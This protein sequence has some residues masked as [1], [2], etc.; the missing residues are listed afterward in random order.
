MDEGEGLDHI[1]S[2][3]I[4]RVT[5]QLVQ[6]PASH[7]HVAHHRQPLTLGQMRHVFEQNCGL[8]FIAHKQHRLSHGVGACTVGVGKRLLAPVVPAHQW[9]IDLP[10]PRFAFD[11]IFDRPSPH[12]VRQQYAGLGRLVFDCQAFDHRLYAPF[13][14]EADTK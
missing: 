4:E 5:H 9:E 3:L 2:D 10:F 12:R 13:V 6:H 1:E 7:P 14:L 8:P 11:D